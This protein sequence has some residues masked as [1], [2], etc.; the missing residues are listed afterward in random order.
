RHCSSQPVAY[1]GGIWETYEEPYFTPNM[2]EAMKEDKHKNLM[3][4]N[5]THS[6]DVTPEMSFLTNY[7]S[8]LGHKANHHFLSDN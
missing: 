1:Y 5:D 8:T 3:S 7:L 6:I 2:T 4:F